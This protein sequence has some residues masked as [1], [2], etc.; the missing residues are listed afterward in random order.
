MNL[1][2]L[3]ANAIPTSRRLKFEPKSR[4]RTL[5]SSQHRGVSIY[6]CMWRGHSFSD[7][8]CTSHTKV[9]ECGSISVII[10]VHAIQCDAAVHRG[11][12]NSDL[13]GGI[14]LTVVRNFLRL[15]S[16][17]MFPESHLVLSLSL[18]LGEHKFVC[19]HLQAFHC[20]TYL[21]WAYINP[22]GERGLNPPA[23]NTAGTLE[24]YVPTSKSAPRRSSDVRYKVRRAVR[25]SLNARRS[26]CDECRR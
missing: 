9:A 6:P 3:N 17:P 26:L 20:G 12:V 5:E 21:C 18:L 8:R 23:V 19:K 22:F 25:Q 24:R 14:R 16:L 7:I 2:V 10:R 1:P 4:A 15:H 11:N 13:W